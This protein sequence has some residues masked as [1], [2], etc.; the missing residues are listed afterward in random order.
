MFCLLNKILKSYAEEMLNNL[1]DLTNSGQTAGHVH[2]GK[3]TRFIED[4]DS[5]LI[6]RQNENKGPG[7]EQ[8]DRVNKN[9]R[10][11]LFRSHLF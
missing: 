8:D 7:E 4:P 6:S 5:F 10:S 1:K 11:L 2:N 9:Q 3:E